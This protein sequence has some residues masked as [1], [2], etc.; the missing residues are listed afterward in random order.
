MIEKSCANPGCSRTFLPNRNQLYCR[1]EHRLGTQQPGGSQRWRERRSCVR[2]GVIF[3]PHTP[4]H[5]YCCTDCREEA[6]ANG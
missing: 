5:R 3:R 2:C 4:N 6:Y 1:P